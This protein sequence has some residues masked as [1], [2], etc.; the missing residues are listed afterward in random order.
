MLLN[1]GEYGGK[2]YLSA[3]T[4]NSYTR[5][6]EGNGRGLGFDKPEILPNKPSPVCPY[7]SP[8][9]FGHSG[10]TGTIT[11]A[12]PQY[13]L[14]YVFLSNRVYPDQNNNKLVEQNIR[15]RIQEIIYLEL[16]KNGK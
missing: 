6:Q 16:M 4:I 8:K 7:A 10:F 15:T 1:K 13:N 11:W 3:S 9:S 12:D 2:K 14:V 5:L